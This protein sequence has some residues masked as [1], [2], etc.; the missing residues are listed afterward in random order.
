M[1]LESLDLTGVEEGTGTDFRARRSLAGLVAF[2]S[3]SGA[4]LRDESIDVLE[5]GLP[6]PVRE[7][8]DPRALRALRSPFEID[9]YVWLTWRF[10][11]LRKPVTIPRASR[12]LQ[13]G[14]GYAN[15]RHFKKRFLGY[16]RSVIEYYPEV[17]LESTAAGLLLRP[18]PTHVRRRPA[19]KLT[20]G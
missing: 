10:F 17:R 2:G 3:A 7:L 5:D 18:S 12:A 1:S 6:S 20:A 14:S 13:F 16:L 4:V 19:Q 15:P 9:I 8:F 11:R